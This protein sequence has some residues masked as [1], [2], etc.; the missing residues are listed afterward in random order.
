MNNTRRQ[1]LKEANKKLAEVID[2]IEDVKYEEEDALDNMPE[3]LQNSDRYE[4]IENNVDA[5]GDIYDE[6][7]ELQDRLSDLAV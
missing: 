6:L 1:R 5:L 3:N 4:E 7:Q 2:V